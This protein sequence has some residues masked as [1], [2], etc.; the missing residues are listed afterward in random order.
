[1]KYPKCPNCGSTEFYV[2]KDLEKHDEELG[3]GYELFHCYKCCSWF[4]AI[5]KFVELRELKEVRRGKK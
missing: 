5:W 3:K 1:M 2:V 4:K